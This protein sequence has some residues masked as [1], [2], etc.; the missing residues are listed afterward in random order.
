[1]KDRGGVLKTLAKKGRKREKN[2]HI[3]KE[4]EGF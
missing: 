4:K 1:L 3:L 2:G